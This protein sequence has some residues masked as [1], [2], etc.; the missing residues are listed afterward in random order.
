MFHC[1]KTAPRQTIKT[2]RERDVREKVH[3]IIISRRSQRI[4]PFS[5]ILHVPN[6]KLKVD[7]DVGRAIDKWLRESGRLFL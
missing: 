2:R 4:C 1:R 6:M 5:F 3:C 7:I